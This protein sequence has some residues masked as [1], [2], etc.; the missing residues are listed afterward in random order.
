MA[1][2]EK[3]TLNGSNVDKRN[4]NKMLLTSRIP[5]MVNVRYFMTIYYI[6]GGIGGM[7]GGVASPASSGTADIGAQFAMP[8]FQTSV[9]VLIDPCAINAERLL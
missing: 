3:T 2:L 9:L 8:C 6:C 7:G 4:P 5:P 1:V